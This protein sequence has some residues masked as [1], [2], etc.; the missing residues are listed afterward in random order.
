MVMNLAQQM[1][2]RLTAVLGI[3]VT[4]LSV[5]RYLA[6]HGQ[7]FVMC[8]TRTRPPLLSEF[9]QNF[10]KIP[11]YTGT[12]VDSVLAIASEIIASPGLDPDHPLLV[13][14][15]KQ[16]IPVVGDIEL[17][18]RAVRAP[19]VAITGS[20]GKS[21][22][23]R[24]L[25]EM[26]RTATRNV[27][28]GGNLGTPALELLSDE[29]ELY[30]LELS[31]FQLEQT[32]SL[33]PAVAT[34][35]NLSE[36][37]LDRYPSMA[38]YRS[39]KQEIYVR[40][41]QVVVNR[42]DSTTWPAGPID[43]VW[44]FGL[45]LPADNAPENGFSSDKA[46]GVIEQGGQFWLAQADQVLLPVDELMLKG[47]HNWAN[48]LAALALGSAI[49]LP[50]DAMLDALRR[51]SG[52][53]HRCQTV[54]I[55]SGVTYINDSKATNVGAALAALEGL[56]HEPK[57][58]DPKNIIWIAGGQGKGADFS[59]LA[60][61]VGRYVKTALLMGEDAGLM[62]DAIAGVT[63]VEQVKTLEH[64]VHCASK[65]AEPGDLVLLSPACASFDM[66]RNFEARGDAFIAAAEGVA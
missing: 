51:F 7:P 53:P 54:R 5:A 15:A 11:C 47:R 32:R 3:G 60:P 24:L 16:N 9:R 26:S 64:A 13:Q 34:I 21:T 48:A 35:L 44:S 25:G 36:D 63:T 41:K 50:M 10:P 28:V 56:G 4:G 66:F 43:E 17:F 57:N 65:L 22:V 52:L 38:E 18:A 30:V 58:N 27:A 29:C 55:L 23:T 37:H 45:D 61:V 6:G 49:N 14:A 59:P 8:D 1:D 62:A 31:S 12:D 42:D 20:N 46:F 33:E 40:A 19:V 2:Q 39:A